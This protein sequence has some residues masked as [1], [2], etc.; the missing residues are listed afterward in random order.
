MEFLTRDRWGARPRSYNPG[1]V[2]PSMGVFIHYNGGNPLPAAVVSGDFQAVASHLRSV[3]NHHMDGNGWPDIA[4]SWCV[5]GMGRIWELRGWGVAG[6][7]TLDWNWQSHAIYLPIGGDQSPTEAQIAG[8]RQVIAEH[9]R[10]FGAGFIKGHQQA[11]STSC[12]GG[13]TMALL[14]AGRFDPNIEQPEPEPEEEDEDMAKS[15]IVKDPRPDGRH[16]HVFGNQRYR[17]ES[18]DEI[19]ALKFLG[20]PVITEG[21][22]ALVSWLRACKDLG[23]PKGR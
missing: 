9:N 13:P 3:Q 2:S 21:G 14:R 12:P 11:N 8:C 19:E 5:D 6:A 16:W 22:D 23:R 1:V 10:K 7:H 18:Q 17:I 15:V 20:A 4:Y